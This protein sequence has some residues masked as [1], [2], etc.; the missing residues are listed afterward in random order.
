M[1]DT[2]NGFYKIGKSVNPSYRE[3]TLMA[4]KP[5]I[6]LIFS[7]KEKG[8]FTEKNLHSLFSECRIRGEWF[9]LSKAQVRYICHLGRKAQ[10]RI[11]YM[12]FPDGYFA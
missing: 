2:S 9:E 3:R 8:D 6:K 10:V 4:E 5:T 1:K 7:E 11:K 12:Y